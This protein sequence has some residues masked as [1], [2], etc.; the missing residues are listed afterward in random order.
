VSATFH[1]RDVFAP[2]AAA[3]ATGSDAEAYGPLIYDPV[4][5]PTT[6]DLRIM[7]ADSMAGSCTS[8]AS[9]IA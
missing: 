6:L 7:T 2:V 1:G 8:T 9:A 3:L 4:R 5:L